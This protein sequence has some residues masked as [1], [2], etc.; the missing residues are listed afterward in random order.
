MGILFACNIYELRNWN[1]DAKHL[2]DRNKLLPLYLI[3]GPVQLL[4]RVN[5]QMVSNAICSSLF[6]L[7]LCAKF[8]EMM[9]SFPGYVF[10]MHSDLLRHNLCIILKHKNAFNNI[11]FSY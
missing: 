5:S 7:R 8:D 6:R 3:Y 11:V 1:D 9:F 4:C 10:L 2:S